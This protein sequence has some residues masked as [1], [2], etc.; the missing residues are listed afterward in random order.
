[1]ELLR[2]ETLCGF[3]QASLSRLGST[4]HGVSIRL[5]LADG[6]PTG[7]W[8]VEKSNWTGVGTVVP[9]TEYSRARSM[10]P[11]LSRAGIYVLVGPSETQPERERIYIGEADVLRNRQDLSP[12]PNN[13]KLVTDVRVEEVRDTESASAAFTG[14]SANVGTFDTRVCCCIA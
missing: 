12:S 8:V 3:R 14:V 5:F 11:E 9:R 4:L 13:A 7:I 6:V 10:R 1:V 2:S